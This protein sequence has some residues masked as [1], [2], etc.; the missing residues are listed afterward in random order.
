MTEVEKEQRDESVNKWWE[1][2]MR[3]QRPWCTR[4]KGD[5][6]LHV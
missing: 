5:S 2:N 3:P 4:V 6:H 1:W